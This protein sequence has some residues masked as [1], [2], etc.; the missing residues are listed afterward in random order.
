MFKPTLTFLLL[1]VLYA[2]AQDLN[3]NMLTTLDAGVN[4]SS[5]LINIDGRIITHN[6]SGDGAKL[7]E[8]DDSDGSITRTVTIENAGSTDWEDICHD[9]TYIYIGDFGNNAG[10]RTDLAIYRVAIS[11]YLASDIVTCDTIRFNY[12]DQTDF[13]PATYSTNYDAEAFIAY[14]DSLYVFTKNWGNSETNV[15]SIP[16]IPGDYSV[17]IIDNFNPEGLVTGADYDAEKGELLLTGYVLTSPFCYYIRSFT[18][19][20]FSGGSAMRYN[21]SIS[22]SKQIEAVTALGG[23]TFYISS[24]DAVTGGPHLHEVKLSNFASLENSDERIINCFPNPT[25]AFIRAQL[26]KNATAYLLD[27]KGHVLI[28]SQDPT[29]DLTGLAKGLYIL[30]V[31][32]ANNQTLYTEQLIKR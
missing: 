4:E 21:V 25:S 7:Y 26:P 20:L 17:S 29:I 15:Y 32:D 10:T 2:H 27:L 3:V 5:G 13:E 18:G 8:I 24:E 28:T 31:V 6:D 9:G 30:K 11:D 23:H 14:N 19:H 1:S 12:S 22:G 16:K